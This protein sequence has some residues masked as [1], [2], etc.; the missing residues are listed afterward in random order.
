MQSNASIQIQP[1]DPI[2]PAAPVRRSRFR[3]GRQRAGYFFMLP[4]L[5]LLLIFM[6]GPAFYALY[7]AF[8]NMALTGFG[9]AS[10]QWIGWQNF[11][12]IFHDPD[13]F[14]SLR[15]SVTYL[16]GSALIGQAGLGLLLALLMQRRNTS[17][18]AVVGAIVVG[19][20][21]VPD[22]VAGF[23][24]NA[25]LHGDG[26]LNTV[27]ALFGLPTKAWLQS[28]PMSSII[29][30]NTWRGTAFSMLLFSGALTAISP[31][32]LEAA[33]VDGAG[34]FQRVARIVLPLLKG[35]IATDLLLITLQT[36]SDFTLVFVL[37]GGGPGF[38]TQLM[39]IYMYQQAF[40]FYQLGY[41][42]AVSLLIIAVGA[43][44]SLLYIRV[45]RVEI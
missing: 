16:V 39:T 3:F 21:I 23:L 13:F 29:V 9:A 7:T 15:V 11:D 44:L 27:L 33:A 25:F 8:T 36:L 24:W 19:A 2:I 31:D 28:A 14:N 26:F 1:T 18:K 30:A 45:L 20:W 5:A 4:A 41:G 43:I 22:V 38:Q 12:Q 17:F 6:L 32:L 34:L 40:S 10:P 35:A 37:T 42:T